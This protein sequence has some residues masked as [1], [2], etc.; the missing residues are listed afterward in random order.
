MSYFNPLLLLILQ[1]VAPGFPQAPTLRCPDRDRDLACDPVDRCFGDDR[2]GD[3]D[4]DRICADRDRCWG[5]DRVGD[6]D[7]DRVCDDH[8][9]CAGDDQAGDE[10]LDGVCDDVD[11]CAG[12]DATGDGDGDRICGDRD[13]CLGDDTTGDGDLDLIC[14]D[15]DLCA[16]ANARGDRDADGVCDDRDLCTGD[17]ATGDAD[18]DGLC[19]DRD[20]C[21][22]N[23]YVGDRDADGWCDDRDVCW[24][25]DDRLLNL[26]G[27]AVCD[28]RDICQGDNTTLDWDFDH[29]CGDRDQCHGDDAAGDADQDGVCDDLDGCAAGEVDLDGDGFCQ[30]LCAGHDLTGDR[31][32]DGLCDDVDPCDDTQVAPGTA[33]DVPS[34]LPV[35]PCVGTPILVLGRNTGFVTC[36]DGTVNRLFDSSGWL[37]PDTE[38]PPNA[39]SWYGFTHA[40][41]SDAE[42]SARPNGA[43]VPISNGYEGVQRC[44]WG[45]DSDQDCITGELCRPPG[46]GKDEYGRARSFVAGSPDRGRGQCIA[47]SCRSSSDC[48][49]GE[50]GYSWTLGSC[51]IGS[52]RL[53]CRSEANDSCRTGAE[54]EAYT[55]YIASC[56]GTTFTAGRGGF[57]CSYVSIFQLSCGRPLLDGAGRARLPA[58]HRGAGQH[59]GDAARAAEVWARICAMEHASVASFARHMLELMALGAPPELLAAAAAAQGDE[60]RHAALAAEVA[61]S[62]GLTVQP[63]PLALGGIA[64]HTT[65]DAV[66]DALVREGCVGETCSAAEAAWLAAE[67]SDPAAR[68]ALRQIAEDEARHAALAWRTAAWIVARWPALRARFGAA[69]AAALASPAGPGE[70][71]G[72]V[73]FGVCDAATRARVRADVARGVVGV[74]M[75]AGWGVPTVRGSSGGPGDVRGLTWSG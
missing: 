28:V 5:D 16:G 67:A 6:R 32:A 20:G 64:P 1:S 41:T 4:R 51:N 21:V 39:P 48:A 65:P 69:I 40:C 14:D 58:L 33:C 34:P 23:N 68:A 42:C 8:D 43:C 36:P 15:I 55:D 2:T 11:L 66:L 72:L 19:A 25:A 52:E 74:V 10:D 26:D 45:C 71:E 44:I 31:D 56:Q 70:A 54:C 7:A 27:D 75:G 18:L 62:L 24:N 35:N 9:R 3:L 63:G 60:V 50:C 12:V 59:E 57:Q 22:G 47:A 38:N 29:L 53:A 37:L 49:S 30:D 61:A 46:V 17:D 13:L 73:A